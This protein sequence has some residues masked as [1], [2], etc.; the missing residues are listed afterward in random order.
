MSH[1]LAAGAATSIYR[2]RDGGATR[3]HRPGSRDSWANEPWANGE[4][5][6]MKTHFVDQVFWSSWANT[7]R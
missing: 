1:R 5:Q 3:A 2:S 4:F 6:K 7:P